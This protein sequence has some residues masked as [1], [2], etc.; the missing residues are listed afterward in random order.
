MHHSVSPTSLSKRLGATAHSAAAMYATAVMSAARCGHLA[1]ELPLSAAI[2]G[3]SVGRR[4]SFCAEWDG[5]SAQRLTA[6]TRPAAVLRAIR[7]RL[8]SR[9]FMYIYLTTAVLA[10][11]LPDERQYLS[12]Q[13]HA[14]IL[15]QSLCQAY[16]C[17]RS[18]SSIGNVGE[19]TGENMQRCSMIQRAQRIHQFYV[20]H[21]ASHS[22]LIS[23][24][25]VFKFKK[26]RGQ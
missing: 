1:Y 23:K 25:A 7:G 20:F 3:P 18:L 11:S 15:F 12:I 5:V 17:P 16:Y 6:C 10:A 21:L 22:S 19:H 14:R 24:T 26:E 13:Q 9:L 4:G 2:A 8:D